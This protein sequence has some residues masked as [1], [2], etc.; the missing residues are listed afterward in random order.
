VKFGIPIPISRHFC[1]ETCKIRASEIRGP[2]SVRHQVAYFMSRPP[3][4]KLKSSISA[5]TVPS[6]QLPPN[7]SFNSRQ[8]R[9]ANWHAVCG[10]IGET[11]R[12]SSGDF[13]AAPLLPAREWQHG[14]GARFPADNHQRGVSS[15]PA[16]YFIGPP[17]LYTWVPA[18]SSAGRDAAYWPSTFANTN[19]AK[20]ESSTALVND[21]AIA[22]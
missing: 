18:G 9:R 11:H 13:D 3:L 12:L 1:S 17:W 14:R 2:R 5:H 7:Q 4:N 10:C 15:F 8:R 6:A 22:S 19:Q 16:A 21:A 20:T